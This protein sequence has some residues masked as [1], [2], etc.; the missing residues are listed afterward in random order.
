[1]KNKPYN[2]LRKDINELQRTIKK[3]MYSR[4]PSSLEKQKLQEILN[5]LDIRKKLK[6]KNKK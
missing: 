5:I 1:M 3:L 2:L 4:M 6:K